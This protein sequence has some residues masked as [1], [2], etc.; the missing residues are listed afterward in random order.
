MAIELLSSGKLSA[1]EVQNS[2]HLFLILSGF[3]AKA[4]KARAKAGLLA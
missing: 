2:F 3:R 1:M 4:R